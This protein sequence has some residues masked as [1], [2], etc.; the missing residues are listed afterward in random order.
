MTGKVGRTEDGRR[1]HIEEGPSDHT[2]FI[3]IRL[4]VRPS[5]LPSLVVLL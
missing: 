4:A 1:S 5:D 3:Y 2:L